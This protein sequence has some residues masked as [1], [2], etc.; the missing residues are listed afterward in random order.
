MACGTSAATPVVASVVA[1]LNEIRL[2]AGKSP[3]GFLNPM[4]Y[5]HP[6]G[7]N[8]VTVGANGFNK[9]PSGGFPAIKG[10]DAATGM[11]TPNY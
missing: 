1:K 2:N 7:W 10:W 5:A 3:L 9:A 4:V 8:D 6:E 11:G